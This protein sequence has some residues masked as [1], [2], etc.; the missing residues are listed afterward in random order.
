MY[1][2]I[3]NNHLNTKNGFLFLQRMSNHYNINDAITTVKCATEYIKR[4]IALAECDGCN[5]AFLWLDEDVATDI[6]VRGLVE[7]TGTTDWFPFNDWL[8]PKTLRP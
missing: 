7:T 3:I 2:T 6:H 8:M 4:S 1:S 5:L